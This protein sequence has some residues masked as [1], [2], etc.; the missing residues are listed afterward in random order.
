MIAFFML[1]AHVLCL[2]LVSS[3]GVALTTE[4]NDGDAVLILE[5]NP[6]PMSNPEADLENLYDE[7]YMLDSPK[8]AGQ[9]NGSLSTTALEMEMGTQAETAA[10]TVGGFSLYTVEFTYGEKE[11]VLQGGAEIRLSELLSGL[12]LEGEVESWEISNRKLFDIFWGG[13]SGIV[14]ECS[15][16]GS[17]PTNE[18]TIPWLLSLQ[19]FHTTEWLKVVIGE[20]EYKIVVTDDDTSN[21]VPSNYTST[22]STYLHGTGAITN[23][24]YYNNAEKPANVRQSLSDT[25]CTDFAA[26]LPLSTIFIDSS[27]VGGNGAGQTGIE[28][29]YT[30]LSKDTAIRAGLVRNGNQVSYDT[31]KA[32]ALAAQ[33]GELLELN[34]PLFSFVFEDAAILQDGSTA[35]LKITYSNA[36]IVVDQRLGVANSTYQGQI[37]LATGASFSYGG[38]D[39][40]DLSRVTSAFTQ[41]QID[42]MQR[43][44]NETVDDYGASFSSSS[45]KNPM[46]GHTMDANYQIVDKL[47]NPINGT[48]IFAMAGINLDRDPYT[49]GSNNY[50]KP[51]WYINDLDWGPDYHFFSEA[52]SINGGMLSDYIY[53]RPNSSIQEQNGKPNT[54]YYFPQVIKDANGNVKF[55]GNA[56]NSSS[57]NSGNDETYSSGFV[58]IGD[59]STGLKITATGHGGTGGA[60]MNTQLFSAKQIW[61][62]YTSSTGPNGNIQT[63]SEGNHGGNLSDTSDKGVKS[64]ILNPNTY[65]VPEGKTVTY[66]MTPNDHYQIAKLEVK[67]R[68]GAMQ[69]IN[70][71]GKPLST[72]N[73]GDIVEFLDAAGQRCTLTALADHKFKLVMPYAKNNEAV[74]VEWER[75][76]GEVIVR[77]ET[78]DDKPGNFSFRIKAQ[79]NENITIYNPVELGSIWL[80]SETNEYRCAFEDAWSSDYANAYLADLVSQITLMERV[81]ISGGNYLWKTDKKLSDLG[82]SNVNVADDDLFIDFLNAPSAAIGDTLRK[83]LEEG[84]GSNPVPERIYFWCPHTHVENVTTYWDFEN[85]KG[86]ETMP[87]P[88][89]YEFT[90]LNKQEKNFLSSKNTGT[91][92]M[93][94]RRPAGSC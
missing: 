35:D 74:H 38:T 60:G 54:A 67:N 11:Y 90:L 30:L 93:S 58:L 14:Y 15:E 27:K 36:K 3:H 55:I 42:A 59:A 45:I 50:G 56:H 51:L 88:E 1:L 24:S 65:V 92:S 9:R 31:S 13:H 83:A 32:G 18:G 79:K 86:Q 87:V 48:F 77:K 12:G 5:S 46:T 2:S 17:I 70:Y 47:G 21:T 91:K 43:A 73:E 64:L 10:V 94:K 49:G 33:S 81:E 85:E 37:R 71:N 6:E 28:G 41:N 8:L 63:T 22:V 40:R 78:V 26:G 16:F 75:Q 39:S 68:N 69:E 76:T 4:E 29:K 72:M 19:A 84:F 25:S 61:Y 34:G 66:T 89:W 20:I 7:A 62:R 53:V 23:D 82:I 52:V 80:D 57:P 44:V